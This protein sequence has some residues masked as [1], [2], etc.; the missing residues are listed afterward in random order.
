MRRVL[1]IN[2]GNRKKSV[3]QVQAEEMTELHAPKPLHANLGR[4]VAVREDISFEQSRALLI[5]TIASTFLFSAH[6]F[7][8]AAQV[9]F[10]DI[11][12]WTTQENRR[13]E[14]QKRGEKEH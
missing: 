9:H 13:K 2:D 10:L 1:K 7:K 5:V 14:K 12:R 4:K 11:R 3:H 6:G 8:N